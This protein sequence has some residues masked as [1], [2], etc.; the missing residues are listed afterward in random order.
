MWNHSRIESKNLP[1]GVRVCGLT[2][3]LYAGLQDFPGGTNAVTWFRVLGQKIDKENWVLLGT[4]G[5]YRSS[6]LLMSAD[7]ISVYFNAQFKQFSRTNSITIS[8]IAE[9]VGER[10]RREEGGRREERRETYSVLRFFSRLKEPGCKSLILLNLRSL[11]RE[12]QET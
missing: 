10:R 5:V 1:L 9:Y 11:W 8:S 3:W 12:K 6:R 7:C 2:D 4:D